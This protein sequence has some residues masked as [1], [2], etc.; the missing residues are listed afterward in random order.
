MRIAVDVSESLPSEKG[1]KKQ[2][3]GSGFRIKFAQ[4]EVGS[5]NRQPDKNWAKL[6]DKN[7]R[8]FRGIQGSY[9]DIELDREL[10]AARSPDSCYLLLYPV[11]FVKRRIQNNIV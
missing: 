4:P 6:S 11:F 8:I 1:I 10:H 5:R 2:Y 7:R 9:D 3:A